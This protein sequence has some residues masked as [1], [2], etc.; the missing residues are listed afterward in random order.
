MV[1]GNHYEGVVQGSG[2]WYGDRDMDERM[3]LEYV[4][5][6]FCVLEGVVQGG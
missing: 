1:E 5:G 4:C 3:R 2:C 6:L